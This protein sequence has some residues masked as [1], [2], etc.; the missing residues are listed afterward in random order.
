MAHIS[1][2][3]AQN[4][5]RRLL[6][7]LSGKYHPAGMKQM[8]LQAVLFLQSLIDAGVSIF[9]VSDQRM[10]CSCQMGADLMGFSGDQFHLQQGKPILR[11]IVTSQRFSPKHVAL[12]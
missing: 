1:S 3:I 8:M 12:W 7:I 5:L 10:P 2:Q 9:I 6:R 4:R 11:G